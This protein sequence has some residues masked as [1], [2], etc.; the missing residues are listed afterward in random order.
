MSTS[1]SHRTFARL[2]CNEG[3]KAD[4]P[5]IYG[6]YLARIMLAVSLGAISVGIH[7]PIL[8]SA[9]GTRA[10]MSRF[11]NMSDSIGTTAARFADI[12]TTFQMAVFAG[13]LISIPMANR[14]GRRLALLFAVGIV[15]VGDIMQCAAWGQIAV[16]YVGRFITGVSMGIFSCVI[17]IYTAETSPR[18]IR[19]ILIGIFCLFQLVG[20]WLG[21]WIGYG[22]QLHVSRTSDAQWIMPL[23]IQILPVILFALSMYFLPD[24][25]RSLAY[26]GNED[27]ARTVLGDIRG[28]EPGHSYTKSELQDIHLQLGVDT[29]RTSS[30]ALAFKNSS[31]RRRLIVGIGLM[32]A[33]SMSG[34]YSIFS[35]IQRFFFRNYR[36]TYETVMYTTVLTGALQI[37]FSL[38]FM[39]FMID[40]LGRRRS[41]LWTIPLQTFCLFLVGILGAAT[42][43]VEWPA[44]EGVSYGALAFAYCCICIFQLGLG[45]V[46]IIYISEI[47][48]TQL[49][50]LTVGIAVA[51]QW[52]FSMALSRALPYMLFYVGRDGNGFGTHFI[53]GG[54][55][56]VVFIFV[57]YFVP[58]TKGVTLEK[59][60]DLFNSTT[61]NHAE[62]V[63]DADESTS[64]STSTAEAIEMDN[65]RQYDP[66][67]PRRAKNLSDDEWQQYVPLV[68]VY[69]QYGVSLKDIVKVLQT[70]AGLTISYKR[71]AER[72]AR[73]NARRQPPSGAAPYEAS[74]DEVQ[75]DET[76]IAPATLDTSPSL[77]G[78]ASSLE[79]DVP[80]AA[81]STTFS[82]RPRIESKTTEPQFPTPVIHPYNE[83]LVHT[84]TTTGSTVPGDLKDTI[85][86]ELWAQLVAIVSSEYDLFDIFADYDVHTSPSMARVGEV[87]IFSVG[88]LSSHTN[89][90]VDWTDG[91]AEPYDIYGL[92]QMADCHATLGLRSHAFA[93]Y[94]RGFRL[95]SQLGIRQYMAASRCKI[96]VQYLLWGIIGYVTTCS[97]PASVKYTITCL[98]SIEEVLR[99]HDRVDAGTKIIL[100]T[101]RALLEGQTFE[102]VQCPSLEDLRG[103]HNLFDSLH[104]A[105][106]LREA[107]FL[108]S[109]ALHP[110]RS[111]S[112][113]LHPDRN[114]PSSTLA[115]LLLDSICVD[116]QKQISAYSSAEW[117]GY[118]AT[119]GFVKA[120]TKAVAL[121]DPDQVSWSHPCP[122]VAW[123]CTQRTMDEAGS[124]F[125][126]RPY[127]YHGALM[128]HKEHANEAVNPR[129]FLARYLEGLRDRITLNRPLNNDSSD[130]LMQVIN[131]SSLAIIAERK[132]YGLSHVK[133]EHL[134]DHRGH[135]NQ[136]VEPSI[137][138]SSLSADTRD[139]RQ[140]ARRANR[141]PINRKLA[142]TDA[143]QGIEER[144]SSAMSISTHESWPVHRLTNFP[145]EQKH[146]DEI[147]DHNTD[148]LAGDL[149][150][151]L[152]RRR[153]ER[154][155][156]PYVSANKGQP[157]SNE[158]PESYTSWGGEWASYPDHHGGF[159]LDSVMEELKSL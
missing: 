146:A 47:P 41:L 142:I 28:L 144:F 99:Q 60:D 29:E 50:A 45:P 13:A 31:H 75:S 8:G 150:P 86:G 105:I 134:R 62:V 54:C 22:T 124:H 122:I 70:E 20:D 92:F 112:I 143:M 119:I 72:I 156:D 83:P 65:V 149:P 135:S 87:E 127:H 155:R 133:P 102:T 94:L 148:H 139:F 7:G 131:A 34:F 71:L 152:D 147:G 107:H 159:H 19:G 26:R 16:I 36:S 82:L 117:T 77:N 120:F 130:G 136:P 66:Q 9:M 113:A 110:D 23:A 121:S 59:M 96:L 63:D 93:L 5:Q 100:S 81:Q 128:W 104:P 42:R 25:P 35:P 108:I 137:D 115:I 91:D 103:Y 11:D 58:E 95:I 76:L 38:G 157:E 101:Y 55:C 43:N 140:T 15:L 40:R 90:Q 51:V 97:G 151:K 80:A 27:D 74:D 154:V 73:Q 141:D 2:V 79:V 89:N 145:E 67:K 44:I 123:Y 1:L 129:E 14:L 114:Y 18:T 3:I 4:P 125:Q 57:W 46:P 109:I 12:T 49:R 132:V 116:L 88:M 30:F 69:R 158:V 153:S 138:T 39:L 78:R 32:I 6:R 56:I 126:W 37:V 64:I 61:A 17:P 85:L 52:L 106:R 10:F 111:I 98:D 53:F 48:T 24:T 33:Q 68:E 84:S 118:I 21:F